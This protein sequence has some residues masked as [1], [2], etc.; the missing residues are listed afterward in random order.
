MTNEMIVYEYDEL[1]DMEY[2]GAFRKIDTNLIKY[3]T[4]RVRKTIEYKNFIDYVKKNLNIN[5]CSFYKDY[6]I[7]RGFTIELHHSPFTLYDYVETVCNKHYAMDKHDP[8]VYCW[9]VEE[10]VNQLHYEFMVGLVPLNPSAH[11]LVHSGNLT[12]HPRMVNF[13]WNHF[14]SEYQE[15]ISDEI[16]GKIEEFEIL[17]L[18]DPDTIPNI[19][20][21]KPVIIN[22]MKFKSLG[23]VNIENIIISKLRTRFEESQRLE[24]KRA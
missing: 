18:T 20:K 17:G 16:K 9:R 11:K 6:S 10:E 13:K 5:H 23:S 3:I 8:R 7:D 22:N 14:I 24:E 15:H 21:Y 4:H 19:V 1:P 2:D 12:V